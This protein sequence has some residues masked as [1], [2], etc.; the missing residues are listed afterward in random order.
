MLKNIFMALKLGGGGGGGGLELVCVRP[1][2]AFGSVLVQ[3]TKQL[4]T[5]KIRGSSRICYYGERRFSEKSD[6]FYETE[7][8]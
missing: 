2:L 5:T 4:R 1:T 3:Q 6:D 7:Q 8:N